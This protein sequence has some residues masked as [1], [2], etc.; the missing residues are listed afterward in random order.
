MAT[1]VTTT[2]TYV[3]VTSTTN[4]VVI[5]TRMSRNPGAFKDIGK[6]ASDFLN[7]NFYENEWKVEVNAGAADG[8]TVKATVAK[9]E[10]TTVG[11]LEHKTKHKSGADVTTVIDLN[12]DLKTTVAFKNKFV[13]GLDTSAEFSTNST[14]IF[15]AL[16]VKLSADY[17]HDVVTLSSNVNIPFAANAAPSSVTSVVLG[18]KEQGVALG[19]EVEFNAARAQ[20]TRFDTGLSYAKASTSVTAFSRSKRD[21]STNNLANRVGLNVHH[22]FA[23]ANGSNAAVEAIYDLKTSLVSISAGYAFKPDAAS[24]FKARINNQGVLGL[25]YTQNLNPPFSVGLFANANLLNLESNDALKVG[26][27]VAYTQ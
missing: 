6:D 13:K 26:F 18:S 2:T 3:P 8:T 21:T 17:A 4:Y 19:A 16:K 27:K 14:R 15:D 23:S 11:S 12:R 25:A 22:K 10:A 7:K 1:T 20:V 5:P 24:S 9:G